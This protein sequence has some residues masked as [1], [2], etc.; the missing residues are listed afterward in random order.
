M[1][2]N[3]YEEYYEKAQ[4][5]RKGG[6]IAFCVVAFL[7][8]ALVV[9]WSIGSDG[10]K[11]NNPLKF[12]NSWGTAITQTES[13]G[14][15]QNGEN[16]KP[17]GNSASVVGGS[18]IS[19]IR[20]NGVT[21][22]KAVLPRAAYAVNGVSEQAESAYTLTAEVLPDYATDKSL[23]WTQL[24]WLNGES[25]WV[26]GKAVTDYVTVTANGDNSAVLACLQDFG[27]PIVLTVSSVSNPE[28]FATCHIDYYQRVKSCDFAVYYD[29]AEVTPTVSNG[30]Y[31]VDYTGAEKD[32]TV[33][34]RPVYSNYTLTDTYTTTIN[35]ALSD[36]FGYTATSTLTA[37]TLPAGLTGGEPELSENALNWC[38]YI[39]RLIFS[40][41]KY[42]PETIGIGKGLC[43][44]NNVDIHQST[45]K[46]TY[47]LTDEEKQH[48]RCA[49]Y[50]SIIENM[51]ISEE[52]FNQAKIEYENYQPAAYS[53]VGNI[54]IPSYNAFVMAVQSCNSN[55]AGVIE[56]AINI[57]GAHSNYET[58]LKL[59]YNDE[60]KTNVQ[61]MTLS[62][63]NIAF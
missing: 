8:A 3:Y 24:D 51:A 12:F 57:S 44:G 35:G 11:Q 22:L 63:S 16:V 27:E 13:E 48:P 60:F 33:E 23:D 59:S 55:G 15:G 53:F 52:G 43:L 54:T 30:V 31:K 14:N 40:K 56:Y 46:P 36:T 28:V 45:I 29:G 18:E 5:K 25:E 26:Q 49:Y 38:E 17:G 21:V 4:P 10:F 34:L 2:R 9:V 20:S 41:T 62:D 39:D 6:S 58:V 50:I 42:D 19:E 32:Y 37:L 61:D 47:V 7:L 1:A